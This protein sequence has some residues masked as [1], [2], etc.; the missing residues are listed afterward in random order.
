[1]NST[2][3]IA[4]LLLLSLPTLIQIYIGYILQIIVAKIVPTNIANQD[5]FDFIVIGAGSGG[6][7]VAGRLVENG[8]KVLLVE[9]GPPMHYLQYIPGL[10]STFIANSPYVWK[11]VTEP[12]K[13][14]RKTYR[15]PRYYYGKSLGGSSALNFMQYVRGNGKDYDEWESFGNPGWKFKDVLPYFKKSE[16]FHNPTNSKIPIDP[17]FHG[18]HGR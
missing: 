2:I 18:N 11:Y 4:L 17:E 5:E 10:H 15:E 12:Q 9:A 16:Y 8:Y 1:M 3:A 7:T 6:S 13:H 14:T